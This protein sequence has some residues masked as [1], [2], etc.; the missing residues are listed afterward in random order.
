MNLDIIAAAAIEAMIE[1]PT[2]SSVNSNTTCVVFNLRKAGHSAEYVAYRD[3]VSMR[4]HTTPA[5][6]ERII[7]LQTELEVIGRGVTLPAWSTYG[8]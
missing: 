3:W 2:R 1:Q 7:A 8:T 5:G 6:W 4:R